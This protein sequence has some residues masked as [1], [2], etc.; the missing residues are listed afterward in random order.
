MRA[1]PRRPAAALALGVCFGAA[2]A[3]AAPAA[4]P[5]TPEAIA[6]AV[7][8]HK[9][10][11]DVQHIGSARWPIAVEAK[12]TIDRVG[13]VSA[14]EAGSPETPSELQ[15]ATRAAIAGWRFWPA[16]GGCRHIEQTATATITFDEKDVN[17]TQLELAELSPSRMLPAPDFAWLDP[18]DAG[19]S[20]PRLR[21]ARAGYVETLA[22]KQVLPRFPAKAS[23]AATA[24][25]AF[26]ML[27]VGSDGRVLQ[28]TATDVWSP[29]VKFAPQFG[30]EAVRAIKQWR[31]QPATQ[32]G[33]PLRRWA[34][35]R[36]LFN[37][38]LGG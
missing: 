21:T 8:I 23:R 20:R 10:A 28:A 4:K 2:A 30:A 25:Y 11:P 22:L 32:D 35:Q 14:I 5:A 34:C 26:V 15:A 3:L 27:E 36:F 17:V 13:H 19:D 7:A 16:L 37:M 29:D 9:L 6:N 31:F 1:A 38:K 24:G 18:A 12:F 33:K